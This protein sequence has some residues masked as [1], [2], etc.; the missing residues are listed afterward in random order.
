MSKNLTD[1]DLDPCH[2][3]LLVSIVHSLKGE[4]ANAISSLNPLT[5]GPDYF[6]FFLAH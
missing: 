5:A 3:E 6:C 1:L 4:I 2:T